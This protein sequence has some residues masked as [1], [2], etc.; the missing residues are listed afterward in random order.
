MDRMPR[1]TKGFM[2]AVVDCRC[3]STVF[4]RW[5][6][7]AFP[8]YVPSPDRMW[9]GGNAEI[10]H[11]GP[12]QWLVCAPIEEDEHLLKLMQAGVVSASMS[13][14]EVSDAYRF[15][16]VG[17]TDMYERMSELT[18]L[19]VRRMRVPS[20]TFTESF[21]LKALV[22]RKEGRF[23]VGYDSSYATMISNIL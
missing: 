12:E 6:K 11:A 9:V 7:Q 22:V 17:G 20:A 19:N 8:G 1:E 10:I 4:E 21:G 5:A 23:E 3:P 2:K 14:V 16:V 15:F 18:S 13:L